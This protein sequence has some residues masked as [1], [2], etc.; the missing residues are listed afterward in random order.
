V[1]GAAAVVVD[2]ILKNPTQVQKEVMD[3]TLLRTVGAQV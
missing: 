2:D 1:I 3:D